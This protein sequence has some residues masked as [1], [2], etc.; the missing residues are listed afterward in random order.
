[1]RDPGPNRP[2]PNERGT[3]SSHDSDTTVGATGNTGAAAGARP[4]VTPARMGRYPVLRELG[5]GGM[6]VVYEVED[7]QLE[8][9]IALKVLPPRL[10]K[11]PNA[12]AR[13]ER[14]AKLLASLNHPH[15]A[16]I[17]SLEEA[18]DIRFLTME[19]VPGD[20]LATLVA[21]RPLSVDQAL[22]I[23]RQVAS[24]LEAAHRRRV[25]HR[26]LKPMNV[27][28]T[29]EGLVKVLDFGLATALTRDATT[30]APSSTAD[31]T[32][33]AI[34]ETADGAIDQVDAATTDPEVIAPGR[35]VGTPGYMSP[36]VVRGE[37]ADAR[38]D[39]WAFGCLMYECLTG[40]RAFDG[41]T[42]ERR[43]LAV[44][45]AG[46]DL[47]ILP[48]SLPPQ[49]RNL[50]VRCLSGT[51]DGRPE[52]IAE[53]R[54]TIEETLDDRKL[55]YLLSARDTDGSSGP[56]ANNLPRQLTSFVGRTREI[57]ELCE[58]LRRL[59]LHTLTGVGGCGKTRLALEVA[60][61]QLARYPDGVWLVELAAFPDPAFVPQAVNTALGIREQPGKSG[62]ET[63]IASLRAK[64]SLLV[65]DNCEHVLAGCAPLVREL[66]QTA[67]HVDILV[68]SREP[69]GIDGESLFPVAP[70]ATDAADCGDRGEPLSRSEAAALFVDRAR[71]VSPSF[72]LTEANR[73]FVEEVCRRL[74]GIPLAIELAAARTNVF[75]VADL[76]KRLDQRFQIL[77][78]GKRTS[79]PRHQTLRGLIDWSFEQLDERERVALARL[80]IFVGGWTL[81]AAEAVCAD[82]TIAPWEML[83]FTTRLLEK[84]LVERDADAGR[85]SGETRYRMLET[86]REYAAE[87]LGELEGT[88]ATAQRF[89]EHYLALAEEAERALMGGEQE[90]WL[91]RLEA[92]HE[93][94][95]GALH[96]PVGPEE[97][98]EHR[99]R[100]AA[101]LRRFW[102]VRGHVGLG[103][104][105]LANVLSGDDETAPNP[106]RSRALLAAGALARI[107]GDYS[108]AR[109]M[110]EDGLR[111][112]RSLGDRPG[113][114]KSLNEL[115]TVAWRQGQYEA[116]RTLYLESLEI[117]QELGDRLQVAT[118]SQG[119]GTIAFVQ[120]D[121][122]EARRLYEKALMLRGGTGD[123]LSI[124]NVLQNLGTVAERQGD[125]AT[126]RGRYE[127]SL[128]VSRELGDPLATARSL[129]N[130]GNIAL[131]LG[132]YALART[133]Q[134]EALELRRK[135]GD[136]PGVAMSLGN[137]GIIAYAEGDYGSARR[138][139][140]ERLTISRDLGEPESIAV[141]MINLGDVLG[142]E[143]DVESARDHYGQALAITRKLGDDYL[144]AHTLANLASL[145]LRCEDLDGVQAVLEES[146]RIRQELGDRDGI[147]VSLGGLAILATR[148]GLTVRGARLSAAAE[149]LRKEIGGVLDEP[150]RVEFTQ[151]VDRLRA[152]LGDGPFDREWNWGRSASLDEVIDYALGV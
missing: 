109:T 112:D 32:A 40:S 79:L 49:L 34:G 119:L 28:V 132:E 11:N 9:N 97:A 101:A 5:R 152:E 59:P 47:D 80:S 1:M 136:L 89:R 105:I 82:E 148:L 43:M 127:E 76:A 113:L 62:I 83:E 142:A 8:R 71:A 61:T 99:L 36:E 13:F 77:T 118:V 117:A 64:R 7:P 81:A 92:E 150:E 30:P 110:I 147:S 115:G 41:D 75:S 17:H 33:A 135:L 44:L 104:Q 55:E 10:A 146:L 133:H 69:L 4:L 129:G 65:L 31:E 145:Q 96:R 26:D 151:T 22:S 25:V 37:A 143:G 60:S 24:A 6:G 107:Q 67:P 86:V 70:L 16:T 68:T 54:R 35:V 2:P 12:L 27:M 140:E 14:E 78:S 130:L 87:R 108:C 46:P 45:G 19:L 100:L 111:M 128:G 15:I 50:V 102:E 144:T 21:A 122:D 121:Y 138:Y 116:A 141:G 48:G 57:G 85:R 84:S 56:V 72:V 125:Y 20:N 38:S 137:L 95:L 103:R 3:S 120:S 149:T 93:N 123:R 66:L 131:H 63:L 53:A 42:K 88:A 91:E 52:T 74:D 39:I 94:L 58:R 73:P 139:Q 90:Q 114:C 18:D 134:E 29:P 98:V 51:P 106:A 124:A 126:A 23:L